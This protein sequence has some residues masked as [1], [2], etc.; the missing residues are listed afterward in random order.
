MVALTSLPES[1]LDSLLF[2]H[3]STTISTVC[4]SADWADCTVGQMELPPPE[5]L[6]VVASCRVVSRQLVAAINA[7][8]IARYTATNEAVITAIRAWQGRHLARV[9]QIRVELQQPGLTAAQTS[10]LRGRASATF[11]H[12]NDLGYLVVQRQ[13]RDR[14]F[15]GTDWRR[16]QQAE[17]AEYLAA[18]PREP[19]WMNP[20]HN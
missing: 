4:L 17:V 5:V 18:S 12:C 11:V 19:D 6:G 2:Q 13:A 9:E 8:D 16:C 10:E 15:P 14:A 20:G 1:E 7:A 3:I